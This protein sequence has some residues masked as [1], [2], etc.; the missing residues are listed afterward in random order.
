MRIIHTADWHLGRRFRGIDRT[1]EIAI[2]LEQM[3]K[4]AKEL[5]VD[6]V[7]VAGDIFDVPN[8]PAY[9]ERIAYHF[10]C[11]LQA[12]GIP[13]IAIA[14]NHDSASRIDSI[15][16][17]LSLAGVRALGKPKRS[18]DGGTI[19]LNTKNG[20]LCVG[21]MPFASEQRLLDANSLWHSGDANRR[22]NY[23][24][25]VADLLQNLTRDFRD[26]TVNMLMGHMSIDGAR[27]AKSEVAY[28]TRDKYLH[29][30]QTLPP[31][32]QY[33]ALGHIHIHQRIVNNSPAYYS[34]SLIQL[35]FGEAEQEKG[36]CL[37]EVE[38][39]S[40]AKVEFKSVAC[41]KPLKVLK[42]DNDNL[43]AVLEA[44]QY[45][46]GFLKVI[47]DLDSPQIGLADRVR[48]ICSQA[49]SIEPRYRDS[50]L[51][52]TEITN[53]D[54]NNFDP[55]TEFSNYYQNRLGTTPQPAVLEEFQNLYNKFKETPN[56]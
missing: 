15:A 45:H 7:L 56:S 3:L 4:Q 16:Q 8:P 13:A 53:I 36:F 12:A 26:N 19:H 35:D 31:E 9:A 44:H 40:Q 49:V 37:I 6:A 17:L 1:S 41:H 55:A 5:D 32:A 46:P 38:P 24:E 54:P 30:S 18:A 28:Y 14:G 48:Q 51:E 21:A 10:F 23:R 22:Q 27:L 52:P 39:G 11:E 43:D 29:S 34:G 47:V 25:I 2:A 33:V 20:K 42:C 50:P